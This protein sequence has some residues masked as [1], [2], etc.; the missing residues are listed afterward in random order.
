MVVLRWLDNFKSVHSVSSNIDAMKCRWISMLM[1]VQFSAAF[2]RFY[3][4]TNHRACGDSTMLGHCVWIWYVH[5]V[6][7][8][9][10]LSNPL[11]NG[12]LVFELSLLLSS[13]I[14]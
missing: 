4:R 14:M 5:K 11:K 3:N 1:T 10:W 7:S 9:D 8:G 6:L 2:L 12:C 13:V